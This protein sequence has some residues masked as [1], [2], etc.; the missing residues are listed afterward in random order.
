M[1]AIVITYTLS[2][3]FS[4]IHETAVV[5]D[6]NVRDVIWS[7]NIRIYYNTSDPAIFNTPQIDKN[8]QK[9]LKG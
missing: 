5:L 9:T 7:A 4:N 6:Q 2:S 3:T 1:Y 8:D